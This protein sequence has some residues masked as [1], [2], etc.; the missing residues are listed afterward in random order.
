MKNEFENII[1]QSQYH[2]SINGIQLAMAREKVGL[3]QAA[4]AQKC[5][6]SQQFQSRIEAPGMH[7]VSISI[8]ETIT[9]GLG[10]EG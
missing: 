4:F 7:E 5:G 2:R 10:E 8:A 3:S 9:R 1:S 6:W